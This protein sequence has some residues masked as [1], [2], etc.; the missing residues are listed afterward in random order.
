MVKV[1]RSD[2][3][4]LLTDSTSLRSGSWYAAG[5][6]VYFNLKWNQTLGDVWDSNMSGDRANFDLKR[7]RGKINIAFRDG[8]AASLPLTRLEMYKVF[9]TV[10]N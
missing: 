2:Q 9:F 6:Q 8:H 4:F 5:I 10:R 1:R 3:C 7:H